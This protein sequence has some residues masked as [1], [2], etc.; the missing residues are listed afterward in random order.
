MQPMQPMLSY[1]KISIIESFPYC[2]G[3]KK[4][5]Q[6]LTTVDDHKF[7]KIKK[8]GRGFPA[9]RNL[10]ETGLPLDKLTA[11][12]TITMRSCIMKRVDWRFPIHEFGGG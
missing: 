12:T 11:M 5:M 4:P 3:I 8:G 7:T 6:Y 1:L 9:T 10:N 2:T